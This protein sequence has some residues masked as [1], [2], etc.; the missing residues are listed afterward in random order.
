VREGARIRPRP[1]LIHQDIKPDNIMVSANN[2]V[3]LADLGISKT[4]D[5][6]ESDDAPKKVMGTPH[7]MAPEAALGKRVDQ[8]IDIYSLARPPGTC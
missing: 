8:R 2:I 5:E 3:K 4:F 7:Y 6:A 1:R